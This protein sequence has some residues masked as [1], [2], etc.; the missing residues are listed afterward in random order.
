[1]PNKRGDNLLEVSLARFLVRCGMIV[2]EV[3]SF[4]EIERFFNQFYWILLLS[5]EERFQ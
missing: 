5:M 1:L 4:V 2:Y 3:G